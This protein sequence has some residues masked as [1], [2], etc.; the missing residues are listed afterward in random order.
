MIYLDMDGPSCNWTKATCKL[1]GRKVPKFNANRTSQRLNVELGISSSDMW[2]PIEKAGVDFWLNIP[3][4]PWFKDFY[5]ELC[6]LDEVLFLTSPSHV[7]S[8]SMGKVMWLERHIEKGFRDYI[9]TKHK[10]RLA[11]DSSCI[12]IDDHN[13]NIDAFNQ[14]G[15]I[16]IL[17]P[18]P[19]N[20]QF[21][22]SGRAVE[23]VYEQLKLIYP[24]W[25]P[26]LQLVESDY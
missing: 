8:A 7:A 18:A 19:W 16:G 9:L 1:L 5:R 20:R 23:Y 4:H 26:P 12:L 6:R 11:K 24:R 17:F 2:K 3:P 13:G 10:H 25:T 14:A 15:G 22:N 21:R